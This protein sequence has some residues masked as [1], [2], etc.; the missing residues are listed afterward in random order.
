MNKVAILTDNISCIPHELLEQ[1]QI[2]LIS[3]LIRF[4]GKIYRDWVDVTPKQAYE[5]VEEEPGQFH[6]MPPSPADF[7]ES[8]RELSKRA[9]NILCITVSSKLSALYSIALIA[10]EQCENELPQTRIKVLD[11]YT[12]SISETLITMSA[13]KAAAEGK[14]L[15]AVIAV[16]TQVKEKVDGTFVL[17]TLRH[18]HRSGRIP[19]VAALMGSALPVK[20][21]ISF[22]EG[23]VHFDS[24]ARSKTRGV[25]RLLDRMRKN[26]GSRPVHVA[27]THADVLEE[28][29]KLVERISAEFNCAELYLT[30]LA[31]SMGYSMGKGLLGLGFY[32]DERHE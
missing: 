27:V 29:E 21:L 9:N 28:A 24:V 3:T 15:A 11:S 16:A 26:A 25:D 17:D 18:I 7:I 30:E 2:G 31:P 20:A 8:Y 10:T 32:V 19:K 6:T 4:K 13:A 14:D 5:M 1:Y 23:K 22:R 12:A